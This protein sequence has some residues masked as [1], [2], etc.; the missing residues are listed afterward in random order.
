MQ[1]PGIKVVLFGGSACLPGDAAWEA[2]A[3][4]GRRIAER[5]WT[6]VNGAYGGTMLASAEAARA[7]GGRTIGVA[8]RIFK[9]APSAFLDETRW[10]VDLY[11]RLRGLID[12]GDAYLCLPGSTGTLAELALAWELM[13]KR[14]IP[15]RPLIC[16]EFW[17]PVVEV[18]A[19][20]ANRDPR[21]PAL[22]NLRERRGELIDFVSNAG[23]AIA[24]IERRIEK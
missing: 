7:A 1:S 22:G 24:A 8:C 2:A 4:A 12:L 11:E 6:L 10:T 15:P 17:R 21:V 14:L 23:E 3:E 18:F 5:G 13:N 9:S 20:D 16:W 19:Q